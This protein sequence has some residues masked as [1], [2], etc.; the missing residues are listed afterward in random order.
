MIAALNIGLL[1]IFYLAVVK[2]LTRILTYDELSTKKKKK[3]RRERKID[4]R[5]QLDLLIYVPFHTWVHVLI[6]LRTINTP[7]TKELVEAAI[8]ENSNVDMRDPLFGKGWKRKYCRFL[9]LR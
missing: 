6:A 3:G 9:L 5:S 8:D 2:I 4:V 7:R 1:S